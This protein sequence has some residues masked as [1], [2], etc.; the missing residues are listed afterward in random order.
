MWATNSAGVWG[1][2]CDDGWDSNAA[3]VVCKQLGYSGAA[4][5]F[6]HSEFG[7]VGSDDFSYDETSCS[8]SESHIQEC[9]HDTEEDCYGGEAAGVRCS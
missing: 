3:D 7:D 4:E 5:V 6:D 8:G 1:A 9:Q 2:V